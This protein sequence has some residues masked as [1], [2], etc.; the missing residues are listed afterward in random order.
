MLH[1]PSCRIPFI[2]LKWRAFGKH[3][4]EQI[5]GFKW[6][7]SMQSSTSKGIRVQFVGSKCLV[8]HLNSKCIRIPKLSTKTSTIKSNTIAMN[9]MPIACPCMASVS[10]WFEQKYLLA[11]IHKP[12]SNGNGRYNTYVQSNRLDSMENRKHFSYTRLHL[13]TLWM[14]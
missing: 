6:K 13:I 10:W 14:I 3:I 2:S 11:E 12:K 1:I 8:F 9:H 7:F 5:I 4:N